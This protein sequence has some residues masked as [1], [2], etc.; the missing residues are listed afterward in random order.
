MLPGLAISSS[1]SIF[2]IFNA[3]THADYTV[4]ERVESRAILPDKTMGELQ[5]GSRRLCAIGELRVKQNRARQVSGLI[6]TRQ[7][8]RRFAQDV[9]VLPWVVPRYLASDQTGIPKEILDGIRGIADAVRV[10][11]AR[12]VEIPFSRLGVDEGDSRYSLRV[13]TSS[14]FFETTVDNVNAGERKSTGPGYN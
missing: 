8:G 6:R 2:C 11:P 13:E 4:N 12:T 9:P 5:V 3:E 10:D 7:P 14:K 1:M